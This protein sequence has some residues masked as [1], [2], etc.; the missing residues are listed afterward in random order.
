[1]R[2]IALELAGVL[3]IEHDVWRDERGLFVETWNRRELVKCGVVDDFVQDNV[4]VSKQWTV[5]GLHY[6]IQQPQGKLVRVLSGE[7]FDA[8]VDLRRSSPSFGQAIGIRL[9]ARTYDALWIPPG[10]AHGFLALENDTKVTYKVTDYWAPKSERTLLWNDP[11]L[12]IDWPIPPDAMPIVSAKDAIG[13]P[14]DRAES[15]S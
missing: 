8:V 2:A 3:K 9:S 13:A 7:I 4:S 15:Y 6:Q 1:M 11:K 14:L 12:K 5:R 10:F